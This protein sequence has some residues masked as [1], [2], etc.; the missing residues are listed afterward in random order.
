MQNKCVC[1]IRWKEGTIKRESRA[2]QMTQCLTALPGKPD[3]LM[4]T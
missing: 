3:D 2:G 1:L 4:T